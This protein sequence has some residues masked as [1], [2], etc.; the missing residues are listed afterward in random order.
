MNGEKITV[1]PFTWERED[2]GG[3][4]NWTLVNDPD[5][6]QTHW[7]LKNYGGAPIDSNAFSGWRLVSGGPFTKAGGWKSRDEA[8]KS[9]I[10]WLVEYFEDE[11]TEMLAKMA[12]ARA[13]IKRLRAR[14]RNSA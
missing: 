5:L 1:G 12:L 14:I 9:V 2:N 13:A 6:K 11:T 3:C 8:M 4:E 10:P 7:S